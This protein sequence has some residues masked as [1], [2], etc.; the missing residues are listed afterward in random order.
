MDTNVEVLPLTAL[1]YKKFDI[2]PAL[3][4][5]EREE[6]TK[7]IKEYGYQD[8]I[9]VNKHNEILDG[10]HRTQ[11]WEEIG[12]N[13]IRVQRMPD[14]PELDDDEELIEKYQIIK[15]LTGRKIKDPSAK[16]KLLVRLSEIVTKRRV[17]ELEV[18]T[19]TGGDD[20]KIK[21]LGA[22]RKHG[23]VSETAK[24]AG[25]STETVSRAKRAS[26][27]KLKRWR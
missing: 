12:G 9:L 6:L 26:K 24:L 5:E 8:P 20:P 7:A 21:G 22:L 23:D 1:K 4:N 14:H 17:E 19:S 3:T 2:I 13:Q 25:V 10:N 16:D 15:C 27:G 11:I 18:I